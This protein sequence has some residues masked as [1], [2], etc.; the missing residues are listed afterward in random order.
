MELPFAKKV[1]VRLS[2]GL[3]ILRFLGARR[4]PVT[5]LVVNKDPGLGLFYV[6]CALLSVGVM[7]A[8]L[9]RADELVVRREEGKVVVS[10]RSS[11]GGVGFDEDFGRWMK[12]LRR[13][14]G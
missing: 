11:K 13:E 14:L 8:L 9:L 12:R 3:Y 6:G 5:G 1:A 7:G 2:D 4:R 10:G